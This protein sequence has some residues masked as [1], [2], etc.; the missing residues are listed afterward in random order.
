MKPHVI[1]YTDG[2]CIGNP[3]PGG[4][5]VVILSSSGRT[6]L[7]SGYRLTTN[8]RMEMLAA[9]E[10]LT[11]LTD[12]Q[13]A[14]HEA[15]GAVMITLHS[16][17]SYLIN[18]MNKGWAR[19]WRA[20][21]WHR[22]RTQLAVNP[23]L[24]QRLLDLDDAHDVTFVWVP[25]HAGIRDNERCDR[26]AVAAANAPDLPPDIEYESSLEDQRRHPRQ[27]SLF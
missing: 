26:L 11:A 8:N 17:S 13:A 15:K 1:I 18:G 5:G 27:T 2:A 20:K 23:D 10:G 9:I 7:S 4:Y 24:W 21:N 22:T 16:D 6:E 14:G 19:K 3:G 25:G 12:Q